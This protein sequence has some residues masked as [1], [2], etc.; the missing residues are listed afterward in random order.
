M[1]TIVAPCDPESIKRAAGLIRSGAL[2]AFPTETVYGLGANG[3]NGQAVLRIFEAK[4]RPADNPL[5]LHVSRFQDVLPLID[6][7][8]PDHARRLADAFWPG[9]LTMVLP[10][11]NLVPDA[12]TAGLNT[13]AVRMPSHLAARMLIESAGVPVAAPSAN[14]S[15]RP[16]PTRAEHVLEDMDGRIDMVLD[17]GPCE[18]GLESTVVDMTGEL[19]RILRPGGVT[20]EMIIAALGAVQVDETAMRPLMEG[21]TARSPGMKYRHYAP[22]GRLTIVRGGRDEVVRAIEE[23]YDGATGRGEQCAILASSKERYGARRARSLGETP[24]EAAA[25]LFQAL[26]EMDGEGIER[27]FAE[28]VDTAGVGLAVMNRLGRAAAFDILDVSGR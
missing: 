20:P 8:L 7:P 6:G 27:I 19:P 17:G 5:I 26:R 21:E 15:G 12:V 2:V 28:A 24:E 14:R 4:G 16:S 22:K 18:V 10:R 23:L 3:L 13:V 1:R 11:S 9:P 25:A